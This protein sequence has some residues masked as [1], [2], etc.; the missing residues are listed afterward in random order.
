MLI[1]LTE[2]VNPNLNCIFVAFTGTG[3]NERGEHPNFID[4]LKLIKLSGQS[5]KKYKTIS[6][7]GTTGC[8]LLEVNST[9]SRTSISTTHHPFNVNEKFWL[10]KLVHSFVH[11]SLI[12][13][14]IVGRGVTHY[15]LSTN[16]NSLY[17]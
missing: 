12:W 2:V 9:L 7:A 13:R 4:L 1:Y 14:V 16:H 6:T 15:H 5:K 3:I 11:Y 10:H 8:H 17:D